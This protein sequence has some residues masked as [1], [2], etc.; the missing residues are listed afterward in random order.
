MRVCR[1]LGAW[2]L[3]QL[4]AVASA[5]DRLPRAIAAE[6]G[7]KLAS[8]ADPLAAL[9]AR[10]RLQADLAASVYF[11]R[12]ESRIFTLD[13]TVFG[14]IYKAAE[15]GAI[16]NEALQA[17]AKDRFAAADRRASLRLARYRDRFPKA[18]AEELAIEDLL[19]KARAD[20][21]AS[22]STK[23]EADLSLALRTAALDYTIALRRRMITLHTEV[24]ALYADARCAGDL[25]RDR[26]LWAY[27]DALARE[28]YADA[29][30]T[31]GRIAAQVRC[32]SRRQLAELEKLMV[33]EIEPA[34]LRATPSRS[35]YAH[36]RAALRQTMQQLLAGP[37]F[38]LADHTRHI[39]RHSK[40]A[41][42][43]FAQ[44][45]VLFKKL[46][47]KNGSILS[48][49]GLYIMHRANGRLGHLAS[50]CV[51]APEKSSRF[52]GRFAERYLKATLGLGETC[53]LLGAALD[54]AGLPCD[55]SQWVPAGKR[56][57]LVDSFTCAP[58]CT[59]VALSY[60]AFMTKLRGQG[61]G[62]PSWAT[63]AGATPAFSTLP[64][65]CAGGSTSGTS[66]AGNGT[67][68]GKGRLGGLTGGPSGDGC[69]LGKLN[70]PSLS[71]E[72][73]CIV[74]VQEE[75]EAARTG[76]SSI[77]SGAGECQPGVEGSRWT[78]ADG[79][80]TTV[81]NNPDGTTTT[82]TTPPAAVEAAR[83][84]AADEGYK[85]A[86]EMDGYEWWVDSDNNAMLINQSTGEI[87][88]TTTG[89]IADDLAGVREAAASDSDNTTT[90]EPEPAPEEGQNKRNW[91]F[92][93]YQREDGTWYELQ[94]DW[95]GEGARPN[96]TEGGR[97]VFLCGIPRPAPGVKDCSRESMDCGSCTGNDAVL[98][99][100]TDCLTAPFRDAIEQ[101][102]T[103]ANAP[104]GVD[105][106]LIKLINVQP[107]AN[108]NMFGLL[109]GDIDGAC[110]G[111]G[112]GIEGQCVKQSVMLCTEENPNCGCRAMDPPPPVADQRTCQAI[113][114][115]DAGMVGFADAQSCGCSSVIGSTSPAPAPSP[116]RDAKPSVACPANAPNC[117]GESAW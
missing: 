33:L 97:C 65:S 107:D 112:S 46:A 44:H 116:P 72:V 27:F 45:K 14:F 21:R 26:L 32:L 103:G 66:G 110:F 79:S 81:Q 4:C 62:L 24:P 76:L 101:A 98:G 114:C 11:D 90:S 7:G 74:A 25:L 113:Q 102:K 5:S 17:A 85:Y 41:L 92:H 42:R 93:W 117:A 36:T 100:L 80:V 3:L 47:M 64:L 50:K 111:S 109:G 48:N 1:V 106:R 82:T 105:P 19:Q 16:R 63:A 95:V 56:S 58:E 23:G 99:R 28:R 51:P 69:L 6:P 2:T 83:K 31:M 71:T 53:N 38:L 29:A 37:L 18:Y 55:A 75:Y 54:S 30:T 94:R 39:G 20:A 78:N 10:D 43:W 40:P 60:R 34:V 87:T 115:A 73:S 91:Y 52:R 61:S 49:G 104:D 13:L 77:P 70:G 59:G 68:G 108:S 88:P 67:G 12:A 84:E 8:T 89:E 35:T 15:R 86:G 22:L 9:I 96:E 57:T